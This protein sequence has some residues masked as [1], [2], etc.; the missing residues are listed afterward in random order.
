MEIEKLR[1]W[2]FRNYQQQDYFFD[3][4][5]VF[6][7]GENG[8]G[9][10]NFLEA[11]Y[12]SAFFRSYRTNQLKNCINY[13]N[14]NFSIEASYSNNLTIGIQV[15]Q[16]GRK[17]LNVNNQIQK[18]L[19]GAY[20]KI[21][22]IVISP[23]DLN[24]IE[25]APSQRRRFLDYVIS[26]IDKKYYQDLVE[27][28]KIL[29]QR[30]HLLKNKNIEMISIWDERLDEKNRAISLKRSEI[31]GQID[32]QVKKTYELLGYSSNEVEVKYKRDCPTKE[33]LQKLQEKIHY[34][35]A[36][37]NTS[38]GIHHDDMVIY[39]QEKKAIDVCSQGQKRALAIALKMTEYNLKKEQNKDEP[40]VLLDDTLLEIDEVKSGIIMN[41][42]IYQGQVIATGTEV[43]KIRK[44]N[45][46]KIIEVQNGHII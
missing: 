7:L 3:N 33:Y 45:S 31:I 41:E 19:S 37:G 16:R 43:K 32:K 4:K 11:I 5:S 6:L 30:N 10:S 24:M 15:D 22:L 27:F 29:K 2:N 14:S 21:N 25:G 42:I 46:M 28:N 13:Q 39:F 18:T 38:T 9:K 40:I 23:E 34:D 26:F 8:Q 17:K 20:G 1:L 36:I 35:M 44:T 12:I